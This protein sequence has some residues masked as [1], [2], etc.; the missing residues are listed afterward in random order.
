VWTKLLR[1]EGESKEGATRGGCVD[2]GIIRGIQGR[3]HER[4]ATLASPKVKSRTQCAVVAVSVA[5]MVAEGRVDVVRHGRGDLSNHPLLVHLNLLL[6]LHVTWR[7]GARVVR[8]S[9]KGLIRYTF[10]LCDRKVVA[11]VRDARTSQNEEPST[12]ESIRFF[13]STYTPQVSYRSRDEN[14]RMVACNLALEIP[15]S[16]MDLTSILSYFTDQLLFSPRID[17]TY[18]A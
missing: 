10:L 6:Q 7:R 18:N 4:S 15:Q 8:P 12:R 2:Y 11:T 14:R 5:Q 17:P 13:Y 9:N 3:G 16:T 1:G